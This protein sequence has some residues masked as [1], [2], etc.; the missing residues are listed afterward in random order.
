MQITRWLVSRAARDPNHPELP[1]GPGC[2][3]WWHVLCL[4]GPLAAFFSA[5]VFAG[6]A[7]YELRE[8]L[9]E[10]RLECPHQ[11]PGGATDHHAGRG[12]DAEQGGPRIFVVHVT[13]F[14]LGRQDVTQGIG[15]ERRLLGRYDPGEREVLGEHEGPWQLRAG[16]AGLLCEAPVEPSHKVLDVLGYQARG[17]AAGHA[18]ERDVRE[19]QQPQRFEGPVRPP[20]QVGATAERSSRHRDEVSGE[21][22][23]AV[24]DRRLVYLHN[25]PGRLEPMP[26][27]HACRV[28][29]VLASTFAHIP[30]QYIRGI[31]LV[32]DIYRG[33]GQNSEQ[34]KK[35]GPGYLILGS[36]R[37]SR[38]LREPA[39]EGPGRAGPRT[40]PACEPGG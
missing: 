4:R 30:Q 1:Y 36:G 32:L 22:G 18:T 40:L 10:A 24:R 33:S 8:P 5:S 35:M 7:F 6:A 23:L 31:H 9:P 3:G 39:R 34:G 21:V 12:R 16:V 19:A 14:A 15:G 29:P 25:V 2:P 27:F 13:G 28:S 26:V 38:G 11:S 37:T 17:Q 20:E